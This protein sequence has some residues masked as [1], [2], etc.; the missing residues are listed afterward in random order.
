MQRVMLNQAKTILFIIMGLISLGALKHLFGDKPFILAIT[1]LVIVLV[2]AGIAKKYYAQAVILTGGIILLIA[3]V[4]AFPDVSMTKAASGSRFVDIFVEIKVLFSDSISKLGLIIM[5]I[6]GFSRYMND[7]GASAKLVGVC[8]KPLKRINAKYVLLGCCYILMQVLALFISSPSGLALLMLTTLYPVLRSIGCSKAAVASVIASGICI[9]YGPSATGSVLI[10]E[11]TGY[12]L[13]SFF[14]DKQVPIVAI[15]FVVIGISHMFMQAYWDRKEVINEDD[16][17]IQ[18][19]GADIFKHVPTYYALLPVVPMII[20][21]VFSSLVEEYLPSYLQI[22]IDVV[23]AIIFSFFIAFLIDSIRTFDLKK[24]TDKVLGLFD[25]MGQSFITVV[26]ILLCAQVLVAGII[27]IGFIDTLFGFIPNE[28][29][30]ATIIVILFSLLIF[31]GSVIMGTATVFN[32]FAPLSA[33]V[34]KGAGISVFKMLVPLHFSASLGR[35][36][37]P[38]SGVIIAVS[39]FV[40]VTPF[41]IIKRNCVQLTIA[42]VLMMVLSLSYL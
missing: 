8:I 22:K 12:D 1:F 2:C 31:S 9:D 26:S 35:S 6:A 41:Q 42:Y 13:F 37:S 17:E 33:E 23:S 15:L 14:V 11:L 39:G 32:A 4:I 3:A 28:D 21:F 18:A 38:I 27:K 29:H 25:Q 7:I 34:A 19:Q 30:Y 36:F 16:S 40:G 5:V 10:S 20:L 24:S